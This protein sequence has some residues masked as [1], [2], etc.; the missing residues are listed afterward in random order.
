MI[1]KLGLLGWKNT[2]RHFWELAKEKKKSA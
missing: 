2:H 1:V